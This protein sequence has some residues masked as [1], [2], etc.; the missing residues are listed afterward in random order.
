[1]TEQYWYPKCILVY[2][3]EISDDKIQNF[4]KYFDP[5]YY[6]KDNLT[7]DFFIDLSNGIFTKNNLYELRKYKTSS[8]PYEET[9]FLI[10]S[11]IVINIAETGN[12][13]SI[14]SKPSDIEIE[15]F[16]NFIKNDKVLYEEYIII[17]G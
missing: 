15:D 10:L 3:C 1:M 17:T 13:K 14:I 6:I 8:F 12:L 16:K 4:M 11:K 7:D 5:R 2:G 9:F